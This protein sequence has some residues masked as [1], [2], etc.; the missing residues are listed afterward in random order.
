MSNSESKSIVTFSLQGGSQITIGKYNLAR[1]LSASIGSQ[2]IWS[3]PLVNLNLVWEMVS[4]H[5]VTWILSDSSLAIC[6][7]GEGNPLLWKILE[8]CHGGSRSF[9]VPT[10]NI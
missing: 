5:K 2:A 1:D 6:F 4:S 7:C 10:S 8:L 3:S 9:L